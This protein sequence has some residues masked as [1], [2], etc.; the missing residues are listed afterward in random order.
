MK[1]ICSIETLISIRKT[2]TTTERL[3]MRVG[4]GYIKKRNKGDEG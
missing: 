4:K 1:A 2:L 3:E